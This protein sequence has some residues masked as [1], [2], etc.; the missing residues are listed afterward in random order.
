MIEPDVSEPMANGT[1]PAATA[2]PGPDDEPPDQY[3]T[4][5][6]RP[7]RPGEGGVG[8]VV[9]EAAGQ[10][11][12]R[13]LGDQHRP[14]LAQLAH[15]GGVVV[16]DLLAVR[17]RAPGGRDAARGEQVLGAVGDAVQRAARLARGNLLVGEVGLL[18]GQLA[19]DGDDGAQ[20][21][22]ELFQP[23]AGRP[24]SGPST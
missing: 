12:H 14:R 23:V 18:E 6:R 3:L 20:S 13:Q 8:V 4:V 19:R 1:S 10:L 21:R 11:D 22:A 24:R 2:A 9:A 17:L 5:P 7:A 15:D 16:E